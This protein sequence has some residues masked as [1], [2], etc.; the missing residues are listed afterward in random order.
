VRVAAGAKTPCPECDADVIIHTVYIH[1]AKGKI[2]YRSEPECPCGHRF[3]VIELRSLDYKKG[4]AG[5]S[6]SN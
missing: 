1:H 2:E 5:W 6:L 3:E 4:V